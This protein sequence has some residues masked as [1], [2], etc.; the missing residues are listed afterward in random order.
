MIKLGRDYRRTIVLLAALLTIQVS[1]AFAQNSFQL[2]VDA[3]DA[4]QSILHVRETM[5]V[6]PGAL[7]LFYP[8]WIPGEHAPTGTLNEM[9]NLFITANG[10]P[11]AWRRD[12]VEMFAF[13]L[14]IPE[15]VTQIEIAFDDAAEPGTTM[16]ANLARIKWN[17]LL[18]Y[19]RGTKSDDV[20]V[21]AALK[22]PAGWQFAAALPLAEETKQ[23]FAFKPV[24]LTTL[25]D[26]PAIIG[27][28]FKRVP[29]SDTGGIAQE[30]DIAAETAD[31]LRYTPETLE[32]WKNLVKQSDLMFGARHFSNYKFLVTLSDNGGDEGLEHHESSENG[33]GTDA[34][35]ERLALLDLNALL[36]HEYAHSWNGKYRR[37]NGLTTGDFE[38]PMRGGLLWVYE[39]LT[40]Y[41]G[42][43]LPARSGLW[44]PET[45]RDALAETAAQ[46]DFQTGRR[47]RPLADTAAAVQF[48]Y[49]SG[50][51]WRNQRR[52][53][54]YYYEGALIWLEADVL[55][56][57]KSGGKRSLD[58]F[59]RKFHGG[60]NT[61]AIVKTY[62]YEEL[63]ATL[64]EVSP[65]D[66]RTFFDQRVYTAQKNAPLGGITNGG[67]KLVF[68][69]TPNVQMEINESR[70]EYASFA[71]SIGLIVSEDG[72]LLDVNPDLPA[73]RAGLA[74][75]FKITKING[76]DFSI[77]NLR[78]AVAATVNRSAAIKVA[79]ENGSL[80]ADY[81][82][83]YRGGEKYPHLERDA[84]KP[85]LLSDITKPR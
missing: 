2:S 40:E 31:A 85:D 63:L 57:Q 84:A 60:Q 12:E 44:T 24:S 21:T 82:I 64:N 61:A 83:N 30:M 42:S 65:H 79:A 54:D 68:N 67:W 78:E 71:Y 74:P 33:V 35:S 17:R 1:A 18:L 11:L 81:A 53:V 69:N 25:V 22:I 39:G 45:Y 28:Y 43:V 58:D 50:R 9:V 16:T 38:Q 13:H 46:M 77:A 51:T 4:P 52:G 14:T 48:T 37:P 72:T 49:P 23:T 66:W 15:G 76:E 19:P 5:P 70:A 55:I 10:K 56:R 3:T 6:K 27:K 7:T 62:D 75:A 8:K 73:A 36:G 80:S 20:R 32:G 34:L 59:L 41:L 29:L 26:S 47:W